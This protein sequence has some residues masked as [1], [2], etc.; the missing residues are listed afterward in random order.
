VRALRGIVGLAVAVASSLAAA[1]P[2]AAQCVMCKAVLQSSAEGRAFSHELDRAILLM[3]FAPYV[4]FGTLA[5]LLFRKPL[6]RRLALLRA[7][8]RARFAGRVERSV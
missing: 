5:V 2:A 1:V 7:R 4:V 8:L 3:F 6:A